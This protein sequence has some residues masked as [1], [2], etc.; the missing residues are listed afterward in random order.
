[1]KQ[2]R[3]KGQDRRSEES[4]EIQYESYERRNRER[5]VLPPSFDVSYAEQVMIVRGV[6]QFAEEAE[7]LRVHTI[8]EQRGADDGGTDM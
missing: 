2:S 5:R 3:R 6:L 8:I 7:Y 1:M 4:C